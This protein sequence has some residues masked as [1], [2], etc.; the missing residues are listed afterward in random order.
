M[1]FLPDLSV[2][3]SVYKGEK[4]L[5]S[6]L[7]NLSAQTVFPRS[8]IVLVLNEASPQEI[9]ITKSFASEHNAQVQII[10]V[11]KVETL[12]ASWNRG[13]QAARAPYLAIWNV[14]DRRSPD[15]LDRQ[16]SALE[17]EQEWMLSYG[18]YVAVPAHGERGAIRTTPKYTT[19]HFRRSFAQGGAFWVLRK[20]AFD[21]VGPFDE[22]FYVAADM[23]LSFRMAEAGI[24]MGRVE[25]VLGYFLDAEQGLSTRDGAHLSAIERTAVQLRYGVYDKVKPEYLNEAKQYR[26]DA[27]QVDKKWHLLSAYLPRLEN[28]LRA[29]QPLWSLG[30][31]RT[32][33]RAFLKRVG[34]LGWLYSLQDKTWKREI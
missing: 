34:L 27:I 17:Q 18:D 4:Y 31:L 28:N 6:L 11:D 2:V 32:W 23:D 29:R 3:T 10:I 20:S 5:A 16:L 8:E 14:D 26:L 33:T 22:Q 1:S 7:E 25:G 15:S 21:Q 9:R 13:W 30:R 19:A 24:H 12:G